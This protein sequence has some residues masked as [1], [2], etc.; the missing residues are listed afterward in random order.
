MSGASRMARRSMVRAVIRAMGSVVVLFWLALPAFGQPTADQVLSSVGL[1][2]EDKQRVLDGEFVTASAKS[3]SDRDLAVSM[4]FLVKTS[5]ETLSRLVVT[6]SLITADA[7]VQAYSMFKKPGSLADLAGFRI[8]PAEAQ[9]LAGAK[10]GS[11]LNLST[12]E[13]AAFRA[14]PPGDQE[15]V[16]R[17]L[18]KMLLDRYQAY[19]AS[20]L[21]GIKAY[22]RGGGLDR[23]LASDL[24]KATDAT[25][26][27]AQFLPRF[28]ALL[29]N[30]PKGM[31]AD[32]QENFF[33][34]RSVIQ[35]KPTYVLQQTLVAADGNARAVAQRQFYVST[36][37]NGEQA[38]A[39]FLPI[40]DGTIVVY[41]SHVFTDQVT[42]LGGFAKRGIG[43]RLM[44]DSLRKM[45]EASRTRAVQ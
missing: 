18:Q 41:S 37:Y 38:I 32:T 30:Y 33:W 5:P 42:G 31:D 1:S 16:Q 22:A 13:I 43:S 6:G 15:A 14:L 35:G 17:Q 23:D 20:G 2:A 45:F 44:A 39:G 21:A 8:T 4:A 24:R 36:G 19:R 12:K 7:Q 3:V 11:S 26:N 25:Q 9:A 34:M 29:L 27:L 28:H 10:P 40:G